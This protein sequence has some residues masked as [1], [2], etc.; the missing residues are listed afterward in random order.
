MIMLE[1]ETTAMLINGADYM[2]LSGV[3]VMSITQTSYS[4]V[5]N[6]T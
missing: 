6:S 1:R 3:L 4:Q 2:I 5:Q